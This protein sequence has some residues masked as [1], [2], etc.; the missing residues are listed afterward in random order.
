MTLDKATQTALTWLVILGGGYALF[1]YVVG[2]IASGASNAISTV[3]SDVAD[4]LTTDPNLAAQAQATKN[5]LMSQLAA[6]GSPR[7]GSDIYN[8]VMIDNGRPD[9]VVH[10]SLT[11]QGGG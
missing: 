3:A 8:Q 4:Y 7:V 9:L 5:N 11:G 10:N 2:D 1:K 6:K